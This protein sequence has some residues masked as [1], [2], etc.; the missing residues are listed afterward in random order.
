M[1]L[2]HDAAKMGTVIVKESKERKEEIKG[3]DDDDTMNAR[4]WFKFRLFGRCLAS[5]SKIDS[6]VNAGSTIQTGNFLN[7]KYLLKTII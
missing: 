4:C 3:K 5:R 1:G 2:K 7:L 6:S